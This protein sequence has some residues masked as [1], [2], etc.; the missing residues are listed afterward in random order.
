MGPTK[1]VPLALVVSGCAVNA[2]TGDFGRVHLTQAGLPSWVDRTFVAIEDSPGTARDDQSPGAVIRSAAIV[3]RLGS[4]DTLRNVAGIL[5]LPAEQVAT[6][7]RL[8]LGSQQVNRLLQA[9]QDAEGS[10]TIR[11]PP[12]TVHVGESTWTAVHIADRGGVAFL[13]KPGDVAE[14]SCA[15]RFSVQG[16]EP[17]MSMADLTTEQATWRAECDVALS[18]D[19]WCLSAVRPQAG[20]YGTIVLVG[21]QWIADS[22]P[23]AT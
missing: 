16:Q 4:R 23:T 11:L 6:C 1:F 5:G 12:A 2:R 3:V 17:F 19:Q 8:V 9:A 18:P 15:M 7:K 13:V 22:P 21:L 20:A 10:S 14:G